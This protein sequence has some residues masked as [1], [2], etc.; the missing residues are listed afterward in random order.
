MKKILIV[1][2]DSIYTLMHKRMLE[3]SGLPTQIRTAIN[4]KHAIEVLQSY[5]QEESSLPDTILLDLM[6]PEMDGFEFIDH[7]KKLEYPGIENVNIV[8]LSSSANQKDLKRATALGIT[9]Y[10][11]KPVSFNNLIETISG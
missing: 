2:D 10:M 11:V 4:G 6:M 9:S 5:W 3:L 1:D 8:V 7:F